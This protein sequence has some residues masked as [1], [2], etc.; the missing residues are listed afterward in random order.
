[1]PSTDWEQRAACRDWV[2]VFDQTFDSSTRTGARHLD[3]AAEV[4]QRC[5]VRRECLQE[6][7]A[8][9]TPTTRYGMRAGLMPAQR[10]RLA[11][12]SA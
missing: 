7:L 8:V 4:C 11:R 1:M 10:S 12:Q 3:L 5:P 2:G 9:E 6:A